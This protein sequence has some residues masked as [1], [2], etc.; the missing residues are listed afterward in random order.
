MGNRHVPDG[1]KHLAV[2]CLAVVL[3]WSLAAQREE[4]IAVEISEENTNLLPQGK[5][6][7]G[8][9][10]DFVLMN[11]RV[12]ALVSGNQPG[13]R[14]NMTTE[15]RFPTPGCLYDLDLR[16]AANDQLTAFRPGNLGG[17]L[18]WVR[19]A[20]DGRDGAA[21]VEAVRTA[22]KGGG[23]YTRHE[24]RLERGWNYLLVTSTY[25]NESRKPVEITPRPAWKGFSAEWR[26]GPVHV[27]DAIDPY[28]KRAYAWAEAAGQDL[29]EK[30]E[31][32]PGEERTFR[33]I[34]APAE[35]P[36]AAYGL[37]ASL[38]GVGSGTVRLSLKDTAGRPAS[39][40]ALVIDVQGEKLPAY[41]NKDGEAEF[42]FPAGAYTATVVDIGR[43]PTTQSFE[44]RQ[45]R[46]V[47]VKPRLEPASAIAFDVR[48]EDGQP[49]PCKVQFIGRNGTPTP[50]FG[51]EY[52]ARGNDHQYQSPDC[53]FTQQVPPGDYLIRIT[54]GPEYDLLEESVT[55][56]K[57]E[58]ARVTG[59]L[60]RS[61]N[62]RG[63]VACDFH[64]HSTPS[65]DNYCNSDD[66]V[67]NFAAEGLEFIPTTEHN[68]FY[69]WEPHIRRLGLQ[70]YLKTIVGIE[71]TGPGQHL[72]AFPFRV[73]P[74]RQDGGAPQWQYDPRINAIVLRDFQDGGPER[75]VQANH[76][77][78]GW[79]FNDR[80]QDGV[81]DGGFAGFEKLVDAAETWS[82]EIL[83]LSPTYKVRVGNRVEE[84]ENRTF[85]WL[86]MLNQGRHVWCVA[87]S[88]A[89]RVFGNGVGA[90]RTYVPSSTDEPSKIDYR[91][92]IRNAKAGRMMI[93][94]GPFLEVTTADGLPIGSH[95]ISAGSIAL[96]VRVQ[97]P[98]WIEVNRVQILVNGRPRPEDNYTKATHP[99]MFRS[100]TVRFDE[101]LTV[102]LQ[103]DAHLIVVATGEGA[104]L[105]KGWG[106][107]P[108]GAMQP[109][110]YTNPIYV[111]I[112]G[113]GFQPNGD[114]LGHPI[115][116]AGRQ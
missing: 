79:V 21:V 93:T 19:V 109:I 29:P 92:I 71:L 74:Y 69:D 85:G 18:S 3:V 89:H 49:I 111:D 52:R 81:A 73:V 57:G 115:L 17:E 48:G 7:D 78:V 90:W 36:A 34:I 8:I 87:V 60:V 101:T 46:A 82:T 14:A 54:R 100:G 99:R 47:D 77:I 53:Q 2:V 39:N 98:N 95:V 32:Q 62:T 112:D 35:S 10:G 41:P 104:D 67:I 13:R 33:V 15:Y 114:T 72:N 6:A 25:R 83:N 68:R 64:A 58:T 22:A 28:D 5:E 70:R 107:N 31:L 96:K 40:A 102:R 23:L 50:N 106:R 1:W 12:H 45:G 88:D 97:A 4:V 38:V 43:E 103:E 27:A 113:K 84:R 94:N 11:G 80:N 37:V 105:K 16:G 110:A 91:E 56:G 116:V 108:Q 86:Q 55:V 30:L 24:Y 42:L 9:I 51:T 20:S 44:V 66:R 26:V 63:W 61:V 65:G 75:W 59:T 76:P